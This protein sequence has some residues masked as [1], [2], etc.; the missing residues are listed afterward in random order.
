ML[1]QGKR[2]PRANWE[3]S[4]QGMEAA[5]R[6]LEHSDSIYT[7]DGLANHMGINSTEG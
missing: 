2:N 4:C 7:T 6:L 1:L 5:S 3:K